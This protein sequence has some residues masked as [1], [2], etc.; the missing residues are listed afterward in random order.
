MVG[1]GSSS[2][3]GENGLG[4]PLWPLGPLSPRHAGAQAHPLCLSPLSR[5]TVILHFTPRPRPWPTPPPHHRTTIATF[6]P[7]GVLVEAFRPTG[8]LVEAFRPTGVLVE[9]FRP[10]GVLVEAFRPTG[11]LVEAFRPTGVLVGGI[12]SNGS[13]GRGSRLGV[14]RLGFF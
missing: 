14:Q 6:R 3:V 2:L 9:A 5:L 8:V 1:E 4:G 11:V 10:T 12:P 13:F 7:T